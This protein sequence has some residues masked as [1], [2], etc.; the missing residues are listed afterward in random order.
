[1]FLLQISGD[2][3][4]YI[5]TR[6]HLPGP[7]NYTWSSVHYGSDVVEINPVV[8]R[9]ACEYCVYYVA[10][11]GATE[12]TYTLTANLQSTIPALVDGVPTSGMTP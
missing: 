9:Y 10:I 7:N 5:S 2:P 8:D 11:Y 6:T 3:D 4:I 12:S 1:M